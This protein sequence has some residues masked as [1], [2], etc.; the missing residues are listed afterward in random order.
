MLMILTGCTARSCVF[1]KISIPA[2]VR[3]PKYHTPSEGFAHECRNGD[4]SINAADAAKMVKNMAEC[5]SSRKS[6][7]IILDALNE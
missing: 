6:L 7:I 3:T 4:Y 5:E 1:P 2:Q